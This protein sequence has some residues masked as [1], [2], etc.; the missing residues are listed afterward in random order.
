MKAVI[1]AA[2]MGTRMLPITKTIPKEMLPV[3]DKPVIQYIVEDLVAAGIDDIII[4]SSSQKPS[5]QQYFSDHPVLEEILLRHQK[6]DLL[7]LINKPKNMARYTFVMQEQ[8]LGTA[9][10]LLQAKDYL[11]QEEPFMVVFG[12]MIFP[13]D[14]YQ[15]MID[16]YKRFGYPVMAAN[17]VPLDKVSL[18]GV[19]AIDGQKIIDIVEKPSVQDAPSTLISNGVY[20]LPY[21]IFSYIDVLSPDPRNGEL[22]LPLAI[23]DML[24]D[25][26]V[27]AHIV[28]PFWDIG[29][30]QLWLDANVH[31]ARHGK[32]FD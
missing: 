12:D 20:L 23:K 1:V 28:R 5:L 31:F 15:G 4:I 14:M 19:L 13:P 3:G 32:M 9:H 18:Y 26:D 17:H 11:S 2:G 29:N 27:L 8:Q 30:H 16:L 10:A 21:D 25:R 22:Y 7:E 6:H 24:S